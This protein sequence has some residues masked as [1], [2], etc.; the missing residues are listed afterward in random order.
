[1]QE[2][3]HPVTKVAWDNPALMNPAT[4]TQLGFAVARHPLTPEYSHATMATL[5]AGGKSAEFPLWPQ[6]GMAPGV[7][8]V[9]LGYGRR[10]A[11]RIAAGTGFDAFA[12]R[13]TSAM[14]AASG[15]S[16][17]RTEARAPYLIATTQDHW[18][19]EGRDILREV[20]LPAWKKFGDEQVHTSD[21]YDRTRDLNMAARL[22]MES[23]APANVDIYKPKQ[24]R[25]FALR[26]TELDAHGEPLKD[27]RGNIVPIKNK[28]GK[29][30]QQWGMSIDLTTCS[31]CGA[32]TV[33]CQAENNIPIVGKK[34]LAKG[35]EMHWIRVDRYYGTATTGEDKDTHG[36]GGDAHIAAEPDMMVMPVTCVH[37]ESAPCE[38]VCPV[39]ATV[40]D[41]QGNNNMAYN[42]CI[43]TRYCSNNCPY[44]VRRF[45]FFDYGT[46]QFRGNFAG[47][48]T[49]EELPK[50][51][52]PPSEYFVPPRLRQK[53]LEV[54][55]MQNNPRVTVR[56]R[57]VM[58]K[59]SYCIQRVN[60]A[61][62]ETKLADFPSIPDGFMKT[63]CEQAC[64][65]G[66]IV[67]GDIYDHE[68]NGGK[69]SRVKRLR[70]DG[71]AY[72]LLSFLNTRPRTTHLMRLRN[73]HPALVDAARRTRWEEPFGHGHGGH[74]SAP[75]G[76]VMSLPLFS[77]G[78]RA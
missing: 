75:T 68:S 62:V 65:T 25:G 7:V 19:M 38:V 58:E 26:F 16:I 22:G 61:R 29:P 47:K 30:I 24:K 5:S 53:K 48:E 64:P 71:R 78:G 63:A 37:C 34:E 39:N 3:P 67:F 18:T 74:D 51:L 4:M 32:C 27:E 8:A 35:R 76:H 42:R 9:H 72:Q 49:L 41:E 36:I 55:T 43:G 28:Y 13:T 11:G 2:L 31:G 46:K 12:L 69:G 17:A 45:N 66:A 52:Q 14:R 44:K 23:H 33:A 77:D 70:H 15:V 21:P 6:P 60:A 73:P 1:M 57:G 59:C 54:A 20:D 50:V 10:C 40:H 56:S